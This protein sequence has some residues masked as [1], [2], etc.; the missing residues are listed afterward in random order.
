MLIRG[1][2]E[3]IFM[4]LPSLD[5][6][7]KY[8][9]KGYEQSIVIH[10][11]IAKNLIWSSP[12]K[13]PAD[14][15]LW[16]HSGLT[17]VIP[18]AKPAKNFTVRRIWKKIFILSTLH[19]NITKKKTKLLSQNKLVKIFR[20]P[21]F[22]PKKYIRMLILPICFDCNCLQFWLRL[23]AHRSRMVCGFIVFAFVNWQSSHIWGHFLVSNMQKQ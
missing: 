10:S 17:M 19:K 13:N 3:S 18:F 15:Q 9:F 8:S 6:F 14:L 21:I 22:D 4:M 11:K 2:H 23:H 1:C 5:L 20:K 12:T 7:P 16:S